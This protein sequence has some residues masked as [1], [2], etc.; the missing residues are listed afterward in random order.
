MT[1]TLSPSR[2]GFL[3]CVSTGLMGIAL[4]RLEAAD[5]V[6]FPAK[7]KRVLQVFCPGAASHMDLWEHKPTLE[8]MHDNVE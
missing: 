3:G 6:H 2:R 7:A 5:G 1:T 4:Q 8:K